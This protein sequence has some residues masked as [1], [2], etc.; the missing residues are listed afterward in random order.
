MASVSFLYLVT[1]Y[2]II[3][4]LI[5]HY[6][7][8]LKLILGNKDPLNWPLN[9][10]MIDFS[11]IKNT[12][13]F[14]IWVLQFYTF[15]CFKVLHKDVT[16][17]LTIM[18][19]YLTITLI[20]M[21]LVFILANVFNATPR[22]LHI[23]FLILIFF[24]TILTSFYFI[25][26]L[27]LFILAL[28]L[29]SILYYF[30]FLQQTEKDLLTFLKLKNLLNLYLWFSFF[31]LVLLS[32]SVLVCVFTVGTVNFFQLECFRYTTTS[33]YWTILLLALFWKMALPGFH[34][35]KL[36]LYQYISI[37]FLL[38][39]SSLTLLLN[40]F[41]I[42]FLLATFG[43]ILKV[44]FFYFLIFALIY[45]IF[46]NIKGFL[47]TTVYQFLAISSLNSLLFCAI[48]AML[49]V[50]IYCKFF[51]YYRSFIKFKKINLF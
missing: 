46:L 6:G 34:F 49:N 26:N 15:S 19:T 44:Q 50:T 36:E 31:T 29:I 37:L 13:F 25:N 5:I 48:M 16:L 43:L 8:V 1:L 9:S 20:Y 27:M 33:L 40:C 14:F 23:I 42:N 21:F 51:F 35:F 12:D 41:L 7:H 24:F 3:A 4:A 10:A 38:I 11:L 2:L 32:F 17:L 45:N 18:H 39:F 47:N 22:E 28:E 30:F